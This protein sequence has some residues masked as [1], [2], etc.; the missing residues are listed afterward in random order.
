MYSRLALLAGVSLAATTAFGQTTTAAQSSASVAPAPTTTRASSS[1][2]PLASKHFEYTALPYKADTDTGGDRGG[3]YGYNLCNST[4]EGPTSRCQTA[5]V[6]SIDDFCLWGPP[7]PNS[8]IGNVEGEA[9]AWCTKPGRGTR[10]IPAG[11]LTGV[12]FMRTRSY[13]QVVGH[14]KQTGINLAANDNG[15][16]MDPHGADRRGN[17]LGGLVFSNAFASN[18]G[19]NGTYQQVVEW[20]KLLS[21]LSIVLSGSV[22]SSKLALLVGATLA[23]TAAFAQSSAPTTA[24]A[25]TAAPTT[26]AAPTPAPGSSAFTPLASKHFQY[27]ALP[28][29]ADTDTGGERGAQ[30]GYNV[31]NS[32]TE[33]QTSLCQTA[34]INSIDDFCLWGPPEPNS[35]IGNTEGE[36]VAWCTKPGRGTRLIPAGAL[37][38][39]QFMKTRSYV[40]VVGHIRQSAI[41]LAANDDGGEMDPHGADRRGNPLGGLVFSNAFPS[42][43]GN[44]GTF[45]QVVEWHNFMGANIFCLKACDPT[46]PDDDKFCEH[47]FDRIGCQYNAPAAYVNGTFESCQGENQDFPGV[48]TNAAGQVVTYTQPPESLGAITTIPYTARVPASSNCVSFQSAAIYT[49]LPGASAA[50]S[51]SSAAGSSSGTRSAATAVSPTATGSSSNGAMGS[52][53]A[54]FTVLAA[55]SVAISALVGALVVL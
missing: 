20:H 42:N 34:M 50:A 1:F 14:I 23:A 45:Q 32:T 31:C 30:Y 39:V 35:L 7:E 27:T 49:G 22:M 38:G 3:Q 19:N 41:N 52:L 48:Y 40:Q 29:K 36:A 37:T 25:T 13:V 33:S 4:T 2:T 44:N 43:G 6:N 24:A 8:L 18:G 54:P 10:V 15:G 11:A 28:Y 53:S 5:M 12:Q 51:S 21:F 16:E 47:V 26:A 9:V 46:D 55:G 17:P